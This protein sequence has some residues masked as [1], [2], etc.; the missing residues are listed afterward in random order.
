MNRDSLIVLADY[1]TLDEGTGCVHTAPGHGVDDYKT[2]LKY[3]LPIISPV[4]D[5]GYFTKEAGKY[6]GLKIWD[7][8]EVIISDLKESN[9]LLASGKMVHSYPHCWRCKTL[10]FLELQNSGLSI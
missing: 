8:N 7:A 9:F 6:V 2:G 4:D 1:V 10:L 3:N 5:R